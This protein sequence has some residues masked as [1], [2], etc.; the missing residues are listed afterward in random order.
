MLLHI[1]FKIGIQWLVNIRVT[2]HF[3]GRWFHK[4]FGESLLPKS[5]VFDQVTWNAFYNYFTTI[6]FEVSEILFTDFQSYAIRNFLL[7][8]GSFFFNDICQW[9]WWDFVT[10]CTWVC[11]CRCESFWYERP[12]VFYT[13]RR[14]SWGIAGYRYK[15]KPFPSPKFIIEVD[16]GP[17]T[18]N[19]IYLF[20]MCWRKLSML[21]R[22]DT[23]LTVLDCWYFEVAQ[24]VYNV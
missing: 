20:C 9:G 3:L 18:V 19:N 6:E 24:L 23:W 2:S 12:Q 17:S 8:Q 1:F 16:V 7:F 14:K 5:L 11:L 21:C 13:V 22:S 10:I 15:C 4:V